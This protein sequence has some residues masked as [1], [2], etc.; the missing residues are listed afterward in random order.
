MSDRAKK[1]LT[2]VLLAFP[3]AVVAV[4][5]REALRAWGILDPFADWL[6]GWLKVHVTPTQAEWTTAALLAVIGYGLSVW[7]VIRYLSQPKWAPH[8]GPSLYRSIRDEVSP[9]HII[10]PNTDFAS[11]LVEETEPQRIRRQL[12]M[13]KRAGTTMLDPVTIA[14]IW[15]G[16][17][18]PHKIER[19]LLFRE[20]KGAVERGK[21]PGSLIKD[22][23]VNK[24]ARVPVGV[25]EQFWCDNGVIEGPPL[26]IIFDPANPAKRFWSMESPRD[27]HGNKQ[28]GIFWEY[29]VEV[30]NVS[31]RTVRNVAIE[32]EHTGAMP[33]RPVDTW[34]DKTRNARTD[35]E[36]GHSEL[37]PVVRWPIPT[38]QVGMLAGPSALAYG[39][40]KVTARGDDVQKVEHVFQFDYQRTPMIFENAHEESLSGYIS[41]RDAAVQLYT[42]MRQTPLAAGWERDAGL[43]QDAILNSAAHVLLYHLP[44]FEVRK[45]PSKNWELFDMSKLRDMAVCDG[46][47]ALCYLTSPGN[48]YFNEVRLLESLL[49]NSIREI[50]RESE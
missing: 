13:V 14:G 29:R 1:L 46:A 32:V 30:K 12:D 18:D 3:G 28:P 33:M 21:L 34:F 26:H 38:I 20:I 4:I 50:Q 47:T 9:V 25:L 22:G 43:S 2:P 42:A 39:P 10:A 35:L 15:A 6:G 19:H 7:L 31:S 36:P 16:T 8:E 11:K 23:K 48:A 27:E 41:L 5:L 44:S 37:V 49:S 45:A 24:N 40:V 17:L